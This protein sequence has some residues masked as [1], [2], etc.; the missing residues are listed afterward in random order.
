MSLPLPRRLALAASVA[1]LAGGLS[2]CS[3]LP[4]GN[5]T[6][7]FT[8][9]VGQCVQVPDGDRVS[10]FETTE[11]T[12]EHDAEVFHILKQTDS[13]LPPESELKEK[14]GNECADAFESYIGKAYEESDLD[15]YTTYP[16]KTTWAIGDREVVCMATRLDHSKLTSSVKDSGM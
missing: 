10:R 5:N 14:A 7:A 11:C 1:A 13:E 12:A 16:T 2:G 4:S 9:E 8:M 6:S 3:L 15:I